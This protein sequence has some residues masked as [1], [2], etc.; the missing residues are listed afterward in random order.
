[1]SQSSIRISHLGI[2]KI[3][4][5]EFATSG[6][7]LDTLK[8][9]SG[10]SFFIATVSISIA[11]EDLGVSNLYRYNYLFMVSL[12]QLIWGSHKGK[13]VVV[14]FEKCPPHTCKHPLLFTSV[15]N[16]SSISW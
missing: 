13:Q 16:C 8:V 14:F 12:V 6:L 11:M 3:P 1:M 10:L 9:D 4:S 7:Y 5:L 2:S 15:S